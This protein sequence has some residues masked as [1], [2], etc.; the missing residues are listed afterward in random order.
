L[1]RSKRKTS[2]TY[3]RA[4]PNKTGRNKAT[5]HE[6]NK[7]NPRDAVLVVQSETAMP[8]GIHLSTSESPEVVRQPI[9]GI[10][11][12]E[13]PNIDIP[14]VNSLVGV[15]ETLR[16]HIPHSIKFKIWNCEYVQLE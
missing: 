16:I 4:K 1:R 13:I 7:E 6:E 15:T 9:P 2:S 8:S 11:I 14:I 10:I 5:H 3:A 12:P